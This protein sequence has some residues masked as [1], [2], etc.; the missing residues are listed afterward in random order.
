MK[1]W[2]RMTARG[3]MV[4]L[5]LA[6]ILLGASGC[7]TRYSTALGSRTPPACGNVKLYGTDNVPFEYEE[8]S[9]LSQTYDQLYSRDD[10]LRSFATEAQSLGAD[11]VLNFRLES[12]WIGD[13]WFGFT[14]AMAQQFK[15]TGVA[16]K[17]KK[18]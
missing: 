17:I 8:L 18:P 10:A 9:F 11:A 16:V 5:L 12:E 7:I 2:I 3:G 13:N 4:S 15:L 1:T 6:T 14:I